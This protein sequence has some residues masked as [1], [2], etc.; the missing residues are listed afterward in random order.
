MGRNDRGQLGLGDF[1]HR[2]APQEIARVS[3]ATAV[4]AGD[5]HTLILHADGSVSS[6]GNNTDG[7]LGR[8][9]TDEHF[10]TLARL[11]GIDDVTAISAGC[12]HSVLLH[13][14]GTVSTVGWNDYGQLG[15]GLDEHVQSHTP[16]K[17]PG[18][19][20]AVGIAA[21]VF[22]TLI[23]HENGS[24]SCC[25]HFCEDMPDLLKGST[26][27]P[28]AIPHLK[29]VTAMSHN[30]EFGVFLHRDGT[31]SVLGNQIGLGDYQP[32]HT[33]EK[34]PGVHD[35]CAVATDDGGYLAVLHKN[36]T[37]S[38][39]GSN[40]YHRFKS[41]GLNIDD[42]GSTSLRTVV[43]DTE[44]ACGLVAGHEHTFLLYP[45]ATV[46]F[47][48]GYG[49]PND[50]VLFS[51]LGITHVLSQKELK[52]KRQAATRR[53]EEFQREHNFL[54]LTEQKRGQHSGKQKKRGWK[55]KQTR[56]RK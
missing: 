14:D 27:R 22:C 44:G 39:A 17:I 54:P 1:M 8:G 16:A 10:P 3:D 47:F 49:L 51:G 24:V 2:N 6:T 28:I 36:G 25:G 9:D 52:K 46:K 41:C 21:S 34:I 35:A 12:S 37:V 11:K 50:R 5:M 38:A 7:E 33:C 15:R 45:D 30:R 26:D 43:S 32:R 56:E 55:K 20:D 23:L 48:G 40:W 31:V 4:A 19:R 53:L 42:D 29:E 13:K 18:I